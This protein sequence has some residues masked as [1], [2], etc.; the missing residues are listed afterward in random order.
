MNVLFLA[1]SIA[2]SIYTL[3]WR[4]NNCCDLQHTHSNCHCYGRTWNM[5]R[6]CACC[7]IRWTPSALF[8]SHALLGLENIK[9]CIFTSIS[10]GVIRNICNLP[11]KLLAAPHTEASDVTTVQARMPQAPVAIPTNQSRQLSQKTKQKGAGSCN[12]FSVTLH[13]H[14]SPAQATPV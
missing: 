2:G 13:H 11:S 3:T 12:R 10:S 4:A 6:V 9:F 14:R 5:L 8:P 1:V 7:D